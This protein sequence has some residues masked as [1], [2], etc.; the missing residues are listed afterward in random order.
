MGLAH[1]VRS[2]D[3]AQAYANQDGV[4]AAIR[5]SGIPRKEIFLT[6]KIDGGQG[7][8]GTIQAHKENLK[9]LGVDYVDLLLVHFPCD[10]DQKNC[11]KAGRQATWRGLETLQK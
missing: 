4:G 8:S 7:E 6:T 1:G 3:T 11:S 5:K 2:F 10:W 9:C